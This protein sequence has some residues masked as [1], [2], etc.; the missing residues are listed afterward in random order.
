[1]SRCCLLIVVA[2]T[3][4][5]A[6]GWAAEDAAVRTPR[7]V[8]RGLAVRPVRPD[9]GRLDHARAGRRAVERDR[10]GRRARNRPRATWR[11]MPS[12]VTRRPGGAPR[13]VSDREWVQLDLRRRAE[14]RPGCHRL[15]VPRADV[16]QR[17]RDQRRWP[18]LDSVRARTGAVRPRSRSRSF[19][20]ASGRA[21]ARSACST[22]M[23]SRSRTRG[24]PAARPLGRR[25][26]RCRLA[27]ARRPPRLGHRRARSATTCPATPASC[28]G[29]ASAGIAS[30]STCRPAT[31]GNGSSSTSTAP[32]PTPGS[33]STA[34]TSAAGPTA[35]SPSGWS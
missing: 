7:V 12:T 27:H 10:P 25:V 31:R 17:H 9:A 34:R 30:T 5:P 20:R 28:R 32:W 33:G 24:S 29:R 8:Q 19:P 13:R 22:P 1:M 35:I 26:R 3:L 18:A 11:R 16:R 4:F 21:S 2:A 14:D 23:G 15:G 6:R